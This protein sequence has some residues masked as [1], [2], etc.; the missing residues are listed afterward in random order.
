MNLAVESF[1]LN[2]APNITPATHPLI[3]LAYWHCRLLSYL[4]SPAALSTDILWAAKSLVELLTAHPH[5]ATPL[6]HHFSSLAALVLLELNGVD[7][8]REEAAKLAKDILE[9]SISPSAWDEAIREKISDKLNPS[10]S[11]GVDSQGLQHLAD[12]ATATTTTPATAATAA[13][14]APATAATE[15]VDE[16]VVYRTADNYENA[17]FDP[18]PLLQAGYLNAF[19]P[20]VST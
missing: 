3:H 17:G 20:D 12:L 15:A 4:F 14:A 1:R 19:G 11:S 5:L 18:R 7:K 2:L 16:P 9:T 8:T 13:N 10:V 6:T